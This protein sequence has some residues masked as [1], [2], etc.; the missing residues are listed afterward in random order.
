ML[1]DVIRY[2]VCPYCGAQVSRDGGSLR[3]AAEH[4]FDIARQGY[5]SLLPAGARGGGGDTAAMV[6]ARADFLAA[7]HYAG[8]VSDLADA[9]AEVATT[10]EVDG[11]VIDV[12]AGTGYYLAAVVD[13]LPGRVGLAL[14]V[15]KFALRR[16]ARAHERIGAVACDA[17][18]PLPVADAAA[19]VVVNIFAPRNGAELRRVLNSAGRLLVVT[20]I[21]DHLSELVQPLDLLTIDE[22]K[23]ERL[24][25]KLTPH[26]TLVER[27]EHRSTV[28]LTHQD[29][30]AAVAMGPSAWHADPT[31]LAE[32]IGQLPDPIPTTVA[33]RLSIFRPS[34][35]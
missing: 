8:I 17:W 4:V 28:H 14:D 11:C 26:F 20:P 31:I 32:R 16:A 6:Q 3:C 21:R 15:S 24:A 13:C 9:A 29:V 23:D 2:L 19:V 35:S 10:L 34:D 27:H 1:D 22:R 7:G 5:V 33:V 30:A 25:E 18:R 12:G